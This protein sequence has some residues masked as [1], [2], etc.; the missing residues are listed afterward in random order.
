[1][2]IITLTDEQYE[3]LLDELRSLHGYHWDDDQ[4]HANDCGS[5]ILPVIE[6]NVIDNGRLEEQFGYLRQQKKTPPS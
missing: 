2:K 3:Q 4:I 5:K 1:M 6:L